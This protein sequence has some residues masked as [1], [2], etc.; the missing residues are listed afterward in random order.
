MAD[1]ESL[2]TARLPRREQQR[3]LGVTLVE[4]MVSTC[5]ATLACGLSFGI[6]ARTSVAYKNQSHIS[7]VQQ[8]LRVASDLLTREIRQAGF[9][10]TAIRTAIADPNADPPFLS[11]IGIGN[12]AGAEGDDTISVAYAD[13]TSMARIVS[14]AGPSF[15]AAVT[16]VDSLGSFADGDIIFA[17]KTGGAQ[18]GQGCALK[19][20]G[21]IAAGGGSGPK[22]QHNPGQGQ[23][24]NMASNKQC[25]HLS[26]TWK[27]GQTVFTR[28]VYRSF[29]IDPGSAEGIL[30]MS[31]SGGMEAGDW[32]N[33]A[34]GI[35]DI[36]F[37]LRVF[38]NG[39]ATDEDGDGDP[40]RDWFSSD[41]MATSLQ[42]GG[43]IVGEPIQVRMNLVARTVAP[44]T[45]LATTATPNLTVTGNPTHN[46]IGDQPSRALP[47][48]AAGS[49][50]AGNH[51]YRWSTTLVDLRNFLN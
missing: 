7:E 37:A 39:D 36:Q 5:L 22:I 46:S 1:I 20:T 34:V 23:P 14:S 48:A 38:Q 9:F 41:E 35:V 40:E 19:I 10:A 29:R 3:E 15:N 43:A 49:R 33:L 27:D 13:N 2:S 6:Y 4:L 18:R 44:V 16:E 45:G 42:S 31:P 12:H 28:F 51:L 26:G 30:Q 17:V 25:D 8:T 50:F 47:V 24:W 21:L 11:P 32:V